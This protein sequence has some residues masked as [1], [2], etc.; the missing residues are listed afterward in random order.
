MKKKKHEPRLRDDKGFI[1]VVATLA[2]VSAIELGALAFGHR[3]GPTVDAT[4][5]TQRIT[6]LE[7]NNAELRSE[8]DSERAAARGASDNTALAGDHVSRWL[9]LGAYRTLS[10]NNQ[11]SKQH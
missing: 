9:N 8:L 6:N 2:L 1:V 7:T 10:L 11:R 5:L 4:A 3:R